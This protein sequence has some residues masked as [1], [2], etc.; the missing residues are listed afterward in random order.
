MFSRVQLDPCCVNPSA[1]VSGI[2]NQRKAAED[3]ARV[4][5]AGAMHA[6]GK[7]HPDAAVQGVCK[8]AGGGEGIIYDYSWPIDS[9]ASDS[10]G[11]KHGVTAASSSV[12]S[13]LPRSAKPLRR[14]RTIEVIDRE[15]V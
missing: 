2:K 15:L 12:H 10:I 1:M 4:R 5:A 3:D 14:A 7:R 9:K 8:V 11:S 13:R 6:E